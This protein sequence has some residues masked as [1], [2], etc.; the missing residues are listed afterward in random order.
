M[1]DFSTMLG[2][3]LRRSVM[4]ATLLAALG[5]AVF[6]A[7]PAANASAQYCYTTPTKSST[8]SRTIALPGKPDI[9]VLVVLCFYNE[10]G[11]YQSVEIVNWDSDANLGT[12]FND[13]AATVW[14][15]KSDVNKCSSTGYPS[16]N[17]GNSGAYTISCS[18][19]SADTSGMSADGKIVYD[20][21]NDGKSP[22][23]WQL[24]G[25]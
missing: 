5:T 15:Q 12:R 3:K 14:V 16:V 18:W 6:G 22:Y 24:T 4:A 17:S 13:F 21:A 8:N 20:V 25:A 2:T 7:A 10:V 9:R 23:T 11:F 1:N 19:D